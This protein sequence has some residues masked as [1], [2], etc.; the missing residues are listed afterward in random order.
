MSE[1]PNRAER[2]GHSEPEEELFEPAPIIYSKDPWDARRYS[3]FYPF[4][5]ARSGR[6][7]QTSAWEAAA[8]FLLI[9]GA[10]ALLLMAIWFIQVIAG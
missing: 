4:A 7:G 8:P 2:R 5:G 9:G 6:P 1:H 10:L 3:R